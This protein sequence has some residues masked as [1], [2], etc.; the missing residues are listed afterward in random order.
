[1]RFVTDFCSVR[2]PINTDT[3]VVVVKISIAGV[4]LFSLKEQ[5][6][7]PFSAQLVDSKELVQ[8]LCSNNKHTVP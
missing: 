6:R 4:E 8:E 2:Y 5:R 7:P 3:G 1:M